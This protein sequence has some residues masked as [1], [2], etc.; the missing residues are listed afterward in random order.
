[1]TDVGAYPITLAQ[2]PVRSST[3]RATSDGE[4]AGIVGTVLRR[5]C[6]V[7][8]EPLNMVGIAAIVRAAA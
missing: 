7:D 3:E 4:V 8:D 1:M 6:G 2:R 5:S